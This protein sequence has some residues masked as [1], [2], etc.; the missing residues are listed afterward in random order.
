MG[1]STGKANKNKTTTKSSQNNIKK[2]RRWNKREQK[3]TSNTRKNNST[4]W[5]NKPEAA[6]ERRKNK[7]ISTKGKTIQTKQDFL[8]QRNKILSTIGREWHENIRTNGCQRNRTILDEN[9]AM[10]KHNENAE[11]INNI[12]RELEGLEDGPKTEIHI[13]LLKT[14]LKRISNWKTPDH[15]GIHDFWFKK[16]INSENVRPDTNLADRKRRSIT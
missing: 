4:T 1:N 15:D 7:E 13:D 9:M 8:K 11:W 3:G 10:K 5:K 14:T 6:G 16:F 2:E 12:T